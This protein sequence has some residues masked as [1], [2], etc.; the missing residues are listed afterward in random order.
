[1]VGADRIKEVVGPHPH[2]AADLLRQVPGQGRRA[3]ASR[4]V[5]PGVDAGDPCP[6]GT[7]G[8]FCII[9]G[10]YELGIA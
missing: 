10:V 4:E 6:L 9:A 3:R 7:G 8:G 2:G 5:A 1:M